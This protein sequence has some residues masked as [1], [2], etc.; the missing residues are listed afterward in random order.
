MPSRAHKHTRNFHHVLQMYPGRLRP[1]GVNALHV[2]YIGDPVSPQGL[3]IG[4]ILSRM[5]ER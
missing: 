1:M 2:I 4:R 3:A 5:H